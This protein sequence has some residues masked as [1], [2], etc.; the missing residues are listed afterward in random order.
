MAYLSERGY[1]SIPLDDVPRAV[2]EESTWEKPVAISFDD[3]YRDNYTHALPILK[4][5]GLVATIMLVSDF[6]GGRSEWD[7]GKVGPAPLLSLDEILEMEAS[8]MHF[9][10]H[11]A[12]HVPLSDVSIEEAR[13]ELA[14]SK[15]QL[16]ELL[17]HEIQSFAYPYGRSTPNVCRVAEEVGFAAAFGVEHW[18]RAMH[19]YGRIDAARCRGDNLLWRLKVS[20][21]Y[22]RLRQN[23]V[24]RLLNN[25]RKHLRN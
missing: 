22:P 1:Q 5:Y 6:I 19:N 16:E 12:T 8:G 11:G 23:G 3:G 2:S 21:I 10:A 15:A 17:G 4:K 20:G 25:V 13:R 24:L 18:T 14:G 9:G 7:R